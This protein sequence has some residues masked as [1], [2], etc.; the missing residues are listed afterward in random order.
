[1]PTVAGVRQQLEVHLLD[2]TMDLYGRHIE[3]VLRAKLRNEQRFASLD[4]LKQQIAN[5]VV[6]ARKFF[7]LQ[8]PV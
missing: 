7:G 6:T 8:T 3:V 1:R 5:D 4:A 2:V